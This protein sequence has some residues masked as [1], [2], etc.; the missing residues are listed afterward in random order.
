MKWRTG[1][2]SGVDYRR[3]NYGERESAASVCDKVSLHVLYT[4]RPAGGPARGTPFQGSI[5][6]IY[7]L[8]RTIRVPEPDM[9]KPM[10]QTQSG[11][12][13]AYRIEEQ[14]EAE[15]EFNDRRA[16]SCANEAHL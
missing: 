5:V 12:I 4:V 7:L 10:A 15:N 14:G 9:G 6:I 16:P 3:I 1:E 11:R 8:F 13:H 2:H